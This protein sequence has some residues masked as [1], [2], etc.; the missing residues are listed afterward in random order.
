MDEGLELVKPF[1]SKPTRRRK[2]S[3]SGAQAMSEPQLRARRSLLPALPRLP[4]WKD[5]EWASWASVGASEAPHHSW[6]SS[7][8]AAKGSKVTT[9]VTLV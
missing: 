9:V 3:G 1:K 4:L 8:E 2:Q 6:T 7:K 5:E